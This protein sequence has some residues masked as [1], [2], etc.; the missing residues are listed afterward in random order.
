MLLQIIDSRYNKILLDTNTII[1]AI[2]KDKKQTNSDLK[3]IL[4]NRE[5]RLLI[6]N[7]ITPDEINDAL[8]TLHQ[9]MN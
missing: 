7:D 2:R 3:V 8:E 4:M 9:L 6:F 1:D 5:L